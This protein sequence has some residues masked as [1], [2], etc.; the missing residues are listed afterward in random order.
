MSRC[1]GMETTIKSARQTIRIRVEILTQIQIIQIVTTTVRLRPTKVETISALTMCQICP[2]K[3]TKSRCIQRRWPKMTTRAKTRT[4]LRSITT[5]QEITCTCKIRA[6]QRAK[7]EKIKA[8]IWKITKRQ[9]WINIQTTSWLRNNLN[10]N[11]TNKLAGTKT[12]PKLQ[13]IGTVWVLP[14]IIIIRPKARQ[15]LALKRL[16]KTP[17]FLWNLKIIQIFRPKK[18]NRQRLKF[19]PKN[20]LLKLRKFSRKGY[21]NL[22]CS[23]KITFLRRNSNDLQVKLTI[24]CLHQM[25]AHKLNSP[26][27]VAAKI[28]VQLR[29]TTMRIPRRKIEIMRIRMRAWV[30]TNLSPRS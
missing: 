5:L 25:L 2:A 27:W 28:W 1:A 20:H 29:V 8:K 23:T 19:I 14:R 30:S 21:L 15:P 10:P 4:D 7:K 18:C 9:I 12:P 17:L 24:M 26:R 3:M 16:H 22:L 13:P 6:K 11:R